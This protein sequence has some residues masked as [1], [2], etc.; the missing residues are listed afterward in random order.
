[1]SAT[2]ASSTFLLFGDVHFDPFA[3][4][5]L[6]K[7]LAASPES[8]WKGLF[9]SSKMTA[10]P[11]YGS[12]SN[13]ALFESALNSMAA[14]A[15]NVATIIYPGDLLCHNFDQTYAALTGDASQAGV[16]SFIQKTV[17]FFA[18]EVEA[19]F[20]NAT[21][22][23]ADGNSDTALVAFGSRPGDPYLSFT[24]P[25]ISQAFFKNSAD[26]AAFTS[27]WSAAGYYSVEP[28]GPTGLKYIVLNDNLWAPL[29]Y[30]DPVA[31]QAEMSWFS[32]QL[33]D[34]AIHDQQVCV[35]AHIPVGA[36]PQTVASNYAQ[37]G[38]AAY[39][40]Y[41]ADAFN[42]A[43]TSLELQYSS[44]IAANFVGH[45]HNDDF[46]LISSG[47]YPG[48]AELMRITPSIS[49]V[50]GNNPGYQIYSY[51]PQNDS[52]LDETTYTLNLQSN[53]PA[54]GKEYDYA[55]TY[56]QSLAAPQDWAA[57][58]AGILNN[59]VSL[60]AYANNKFQ[61]APQSAIT[62]ATAPFYQAAIG[63]ATP[64]AYNAAVAGLLAG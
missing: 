14:T 29:P 30:G 49:P 41:L 18:Q 31:G 12:D 15:G 40:G 28:A 38:V 64:A 53:A 43:F 5:S 34:A 57:T 55:Q 24:A 60:A 1:M 9:A 17:Q 62:A 16:N 59:P 11:A 19:R 45:M 13:Y 47:D 25:I 61:G 56:G 6:V 44:T 26:Q 4:P 48:A 22:I 7:S 51:N 27:G 39:S 42:S 20:P 46:R 23:M 50:F 33:A 36:D 63:Y 35:V 37:T 54:W 3:D 21:V 52:L 2:D 32:S 8:A 10:Y 58:Y